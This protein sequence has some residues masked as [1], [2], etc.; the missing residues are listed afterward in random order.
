MDIDVLSWFF[1]ALGKPVPPAI[2]NKIQKAMDNEGVSGCDYDTFEA[3][4][5]KSFPY[6]PERLLNEAL[7]ALDTKNVGAFG[8]ADMENIVQKSHAT[9]KKEELAAL[10]AKFGTKGQIRN[11]DVKKLFA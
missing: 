11:A 8:Q 1:E 5:L 2:K 3:L 9:F 4:F 6:D 10:V 7:L